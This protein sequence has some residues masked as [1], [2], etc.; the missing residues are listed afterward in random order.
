[1]SDEAKARILGDKRMKLEKIKRLVVF[2]ILMQHGD[3]IMSKSPEY[4]EEKY[5]TVISVPYPE[6][7]LDIFNREK[8]ARWM[9]EW[10]P[11]LTRLLNSVNPS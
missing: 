4:I 7:A 3:G 11:H 9:K 1:M 2:A 8:L 6:A 10:G 5:D